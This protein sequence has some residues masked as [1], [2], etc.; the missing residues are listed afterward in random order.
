[1]RSSTFKRPIIRFATARLAR[2]LPLS[3]W[4]WSRG[5]PVDRYYIE[6]FLEE[7]R[8]DIRGH[9]LEVKEPLYTKR[10]GDAVESFDVLDIDSGNAVAT[11]HADL[12]T[13]TG[14]PTDTF[15]CFILTQTLQYIYDVK[16]AIGHSHRILKPGGVV[17]AT[18]PTLS[19]AETGVPSS[20]DYWR[21][22]TNSC[23]N[24]FGAFFGEE[25]VTVREHGNLISSLAFLAGLATDD[26]RREDVNRSDERHPML[27][28]IRAV[29]PEA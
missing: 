2:R 13:A 27:V 28:S 19:R 3:D 14:I 15:D 21:F 5:Q 10:Y 8:G 20:I 23:R 1:L 29:K 24:L 11:I 22:T 12:A 25:H 16:E 6:A 18:V 17:L 4:G 26:L 7:H 9:V